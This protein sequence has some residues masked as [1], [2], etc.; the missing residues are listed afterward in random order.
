MN[1][2]NRDDLYL[3]FKKVIDDEVAKLAVQLQKDIDELK[4][5]A[6]GTIEKELQ[7]EQD[8]IIDVTKLE[9][10]R[11]H[12]FKIAKL[13]R[14]KDLEIMSVRRE[15]L[16]KL[17]DQL[18]SELLKFRESKEYTPWLENKIK[19][20]NMDDFKLV[21]IEKDDAIASTLLKG[22]HLKLTDGLIGGFIAYTKDGKNII[23]QS[24]KNRIRDAKEWFYDN[25]KWFSDVEAK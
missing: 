24:L 7:E 15:L 18:E 16:D 19:Q 25:A 3:Y 20:Y 14:E 17:F 2:Q 6:Q 1:Y 9:I 13:Q 11:D 21:E 23:D 22:D 5:E 10:E 8:V 12:H 4:Q